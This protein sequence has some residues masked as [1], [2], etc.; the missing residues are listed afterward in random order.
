MHYPISLQKIDGKVAAKLRELGCGA[1]RSR[2][3]ALESSLHHIS[4]RLWVRC[5]S[6]HLRLCVN[7]RS[8]TLQKTPP[9]P[10]SLK[11]HF[12]FAPMIQTMSNCAGTVVHGRQW[13]C[14]CT[15]SD[16]QNI[17][18]NNYRWHFHRYPQNSD[19]WRIL[20]DLPATPLGRHR[21]IALQKLF[22]IVF[23]AVVHCIHADLLYPLGRREGYIVSCEM[24]AAKQNTRNSTYTRHIHGPQW[25]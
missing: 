9:P 24:Q 5:A 22:V 18:D 11:P 10:D 23:C 17:G 16:N 19:A 25:E 6:S 4:L 14:D 21:D 8:P 20:N 7:A 13:H 1:I 2:C 15:P 3:I 12:I